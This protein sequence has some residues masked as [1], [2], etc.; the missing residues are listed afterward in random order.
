MGKQNNN[1]LSRLHADILQQLDLEYE[2]NPFSY[3]KFANAR[4]RPYQA[5]ERIKFEGLRWSVERRI[6]EYSL[7]RYLK[8]QAKVLDIGSNYG[9]FVCEFAQFVAVAHGV[10]PVPEL[11]RVGELTA[12][13]LEV[14]EKTKFY[15]QKFEDFSPEC[16]YD[17]VFSLASFFTTDK[18]QRSTP[19]EYFG[20]IKNMLIYGGE[21]FYESTSYQKH[22]NQE[23]YEHYL[24]ALKAKECLE[25][26]FDVYDCYETPSGPENFRLFMRCRNK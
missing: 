14:G 12:E 25:N 20:K 9:F 17:T 21:L 16:K 2:S 3:R 8:P 19:D 26:M 1:K 24:H 7:A 10:E 4:G 11:C 18:N 23:D 5:Y 6:K 22:E 15:A 13:F